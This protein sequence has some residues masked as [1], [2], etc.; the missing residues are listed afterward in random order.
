MSAHYSIE[1]VA[2]ISLAVIAGWLLINAVID[3]SPRWSRR[4]P[5]NRMSSREK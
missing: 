4:R 3:L 2:W 5:F 1:L